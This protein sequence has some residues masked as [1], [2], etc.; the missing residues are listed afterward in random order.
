MA[1]R[2]ASKYPRPLRR[3][4]R[5]TP[6]FDREAEFDTAAY[7]R[8]LAASVKFT[9]SKDSAQTMDSS[10]QSGSVD[11]ETFP[12]QPSRFTYKSFPLSFDVGAWQAGLGK[13]PAPRWMRD[14][15][16]PSALPKPSTL[17]SRTDDADDFSYD[18]L[19]R[20]IRSE[21]PKR[22][23]PE[24]QQTGTPKTAPLDVKIPFKDRFIR[25]RLPPVTPAPPPPAR[26]HG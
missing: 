20:I 2:I 24:C 9:T 3:H 1:S 23:K 26:G 25:V 19:G 4:Q 7:E 17:A 6:S 18:S 11:A 13:P 22:R 15:G 10:N 8:S 12:A 21:P 5:R 16:P 14:T